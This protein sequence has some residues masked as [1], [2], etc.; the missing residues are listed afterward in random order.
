MDFDAEELRVIHS[1]NAGATWSEPASGAS[2]LLARG[3]IVNG[4]APVVRPNGSL[5]VLFSVTAALNIGD[6]A[7]A[8]V[9]STD[10]GASFGRV[11]RVAGLPYRDVIG[12]RAQPFP[13]VGVDS[14]GVVTAA[15]SACA[16][17]TCDTNSIWISRSSNGVTWSEPGEVPSGDAVFADLFIPALGVEPTTGRLAITYY[18]LPQAEGCDVIYTCKRGIDAWL[19]QSPNAGATW[20]PPQ[21]LNAE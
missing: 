15:W 17:Y 8:L 5:L 13:S 3:A 20:A 4:A 12:I 6:D 1:D 19:V 9:R 21:R 2:A 18:S 10:G 11:E 7:I 14:R 16:A